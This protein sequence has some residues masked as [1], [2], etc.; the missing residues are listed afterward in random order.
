MVE[1]LPSVWESRDLPVLVEIARIVDVGQ[2]A[3][4]DVTASA[5]GLDRSTVLRAFRSLEQAGLIFRGPDQ[6]ASGGPIIGA[7]SPRAYQITGLHPDPDDVLGRMVELL[8]QAI[9]RSTEESERTALQNVKAE[10][11]DVSRQT[12]AGF[13]S[14]I[15]I[16]YVLGLSH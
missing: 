5:S 14:G 3:T 9:G 6:R 4:A 15:A 7:I 10:L 16:A 1:K 8:D 2:G 11:A 12:L 13:A